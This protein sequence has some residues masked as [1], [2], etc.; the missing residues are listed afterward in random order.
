MREVVVIPSIMEVLDSL[1]LRARVLR[2]V[3]EMDAKLQLDTGERL[4]T[5]AAAAVAAMLSHPNSRLCVLRSSCV[6]RGVN[7]PEWAAAAFGMQ[8]SVRTRVCDNCASWQPL[9]GM[10]DEEQAAGREKLTKLRLEVDKIEL[11]VHKPTH[12][13]P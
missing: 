9:A 6:P 13:I 3:A 4:S 5:A 10:S 2:E 12:T 11:K 1:L 8:H 7:A